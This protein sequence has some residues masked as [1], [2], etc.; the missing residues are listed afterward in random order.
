ME[1][2]TVG[3]GLDLVDHPPHRLNRASR[4]EIRATNR[5]TNDERCNEQDREEELLEPPCREIHTASSNDAADPCRRVLLRKR[6]ENDVTPTDVD[7]IRGGVRGHTDRLLHE[8]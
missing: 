8:A 3:D 4:D 6:D 7:G 5:Y 2:A 1:T